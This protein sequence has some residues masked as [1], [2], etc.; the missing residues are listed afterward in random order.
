MMTLPLIAA[1]SLACVF[2]VETYAWF[3]RANA[4]NDGRAYVISKSNLIL[5][6]SRAFAF[7]FQA[8]LSYYLETH[9]AVE[10]V[11]FICVVGF[12]SSVV[13]HLLT[14]YQRTV[15]GLTWA[16]MVG[17]MRGIRRWDDSLMSRELAPI[18][19]IGSRRLYLATTASTAIFGV[20]MT[21]PYLLALYN[22]SLRLTFTS[23]IAL[24]NFVGMLFLL[25][26]VDPVLYKL[27]DAGSLR[28]SIYDFIAGR[29]TGF[30]LSLV[31]AISVIGGLGLL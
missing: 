15:R 10:G 6:S 18:A 5:Y 23:L 27:M 29:I 25:Y 7:G 30:I 3:V 24:L 17:V 9:G 16:A 19:K 28:Y 13:I 21:L 12:V 31:I 20:A 26:L 8:S 22:P 4:L 14:F 1:I 2:L 11:L